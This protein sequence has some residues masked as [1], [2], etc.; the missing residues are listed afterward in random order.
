M[1]KEEFRVT[2]GSF[3]ALSNKCYH[4]EDDDCKVTKS[5]LKGISNNDLTHEDF[6]EALYN[7]REVTAKQVRFQYN[8]SRDMMT[9]IEQ[10]KKALNTV[11]TKMFVKDDLI[12]VEPLSINGKYL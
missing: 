1:L 11:Y 8:K 5:A 2:N 7:D 4:L 9:M 3:V 6:M 12:S 10:R